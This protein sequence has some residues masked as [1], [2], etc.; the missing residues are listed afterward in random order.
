MVVSHK[1]MSL[2]EG[3]ETRDGGPSVLRHN[4]V[5]EMDNAP[6]GGH[7]ISEI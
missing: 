7:R 6:N 5:N 1:Q 3:E 2:C 4:D